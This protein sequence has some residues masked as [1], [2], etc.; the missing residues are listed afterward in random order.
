[1]R[2]IT[3]GQRRWLLLLAAACAT[4]ALASPAVSHAYQGLPGSGY[5]Y[6][7][8][9]CGVQ[10]VSSSDCGR[11]DQRHTYSWNSADYDGGGTIRVCSSLQDR[12][13]YHML[14]CGWNLVRGCLLSSCNDQS[15]LWTVAYVEWLGADGTTAR[16]TIYGHGKA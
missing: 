15:T 10:L 16:H 11:E 3:R 5:S 7:L 13:N 2:V 12:G 4:V 6:T 1:M 14:E 9:Y 8:R